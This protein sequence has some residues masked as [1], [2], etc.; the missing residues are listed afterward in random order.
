MLSRA[1]RRRQ[2]G[3]IQRPFEVLGGGSRRG[4]RFSTEANARR[5]GQ[6]L[7][8]Q[9]GRP[10]PLRDHSRSLWLT[11]ILPAHFLCPGCRHEV[12]AAEFADVYRT[13]TCPH[14]APKLQEVA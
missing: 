5:H 10:I 8:D 7:A 12:A 9:Q 3:S 11:P 6:Q 1:R 13:H 4:D 14:C 2:P